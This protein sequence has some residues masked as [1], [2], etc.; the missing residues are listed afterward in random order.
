MSS[1]AGPRDP[2]RTGFTAST[3]SSARLSV[4]VAPTESLDVILYPSRVYVCMLKVA[5]YLHVEEAIAPVLSET[6]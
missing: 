5:I 1:T 6:T 2:G 3:S 4:P